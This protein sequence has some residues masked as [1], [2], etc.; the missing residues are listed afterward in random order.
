MKLTPCLWKPSKSEHFWNL[1]VLFICYL[2]PIINSDILLA[3]EC[4]YLELPRINKS[5]IFEPAM[6]IIMEQ[7]YSIKCIGN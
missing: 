2:K 6:E 1:S 5:L 4:E 3:L 7:K